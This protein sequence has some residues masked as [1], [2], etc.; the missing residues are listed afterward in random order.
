MASAPDRLR[1]FAT[2][3]GAVAA[4]AALCWLASGTHPSWWAAWLAPLPVLACAVR[5]GRLAAAGAAFAAWAIGGTHLLAFFAAV[6]VPGPVRVLAL[7]VPAALFALCVLLLRAL[8]RRGRPIIAALAFPA[9][10][11]ALEFANA[12]TSLHGTAFNL[13][14]TQMD[15]PVLIQVAALGGLWGVSFL[16]MLLPACVAVAGAPQTST[17]M[18]RRVV[19]LALGALAGALAF[20]AVRLATTDGERV[21]VGLAALTQSTLPSIAEAEGATLVQ[22]YVAAT[23]RLADAGARIVVLP[24]K[25]FDTP[26]PEVAAFADIAHRRGIVLV[27]GA[28]VVGD[29]RDQ[30]NMA[31]AFGAAAEP[32][33]YSKRHLLPPWESRYTPG[34]GETMLDTPA[35]G[36]AVC[37]DMDF[38]AT[39]RGYAARGARVLLVPAWDF[40]VDDWLH[41]RM[42]IM[43]GVESGFAI[44]RAA[45]DGALT[46]SDDRGRIVAE[47]NAKG[48]DA[49]LV[50]DLPLRATTTMYAR[51]GDWL[52]WGCSVFVLVLLVAP[53][54]R[55]SAQS[56]T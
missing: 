25:L 2:W 15:V 47:R 21:R 30:R 23:G 46:L 41:S 54:R 19:M 20:G 50:A 12:A 7:L 4:S 53:A 43:R 3:T 37:K 31:I 51:R 9:L 18:R 6:G 32:L 49:E 39:G 1:T 33:T 10:W 52:P 29:A 38:T 16:V 26:T 36:L 44:A 55:R 5:G 35:A 11:V 34:D 45:R 13:A 27:A 40:R 42:A 56:V 24:E 28:S 14:Y 48:A 8:V 17:G 22:R